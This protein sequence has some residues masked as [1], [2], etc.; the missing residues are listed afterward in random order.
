LHIWLIA[1]PAS[2]TFLTR[3][4]IGRS[5]YPD[6]VWRWITIWFPLV[7]LSLGFIL[8]FCWFLTE[9]LS[10]WSRAIIVVA[11]GILLTGGFHED[12]LAD[13][14]DALGGAYNRTDVLKILKDSRICVVLLK[15]SLI[16]DLAD[17]APVGIILSHSLSRC[18]PVI[19]LGIQPYARRDLVDSK[20]R[21]VAHSGILQ[22]IVALLWYLI[23]LGFGIFLG[24]IGL[25]EAVIITLALIITASIFGVYIQRRVGGHTGDFLGAIQQLSEV[26]ILTIICLF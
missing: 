10:L 18:I 6:S 5:V 16:V 8:A 7:G 2:F 11:I 25:I 1:L 12:G 9:D 22:V 23:I 3:I 19:Q 15:I 20:S 21:D 26:T 24:K 13:S 14:A 17:H 4:P